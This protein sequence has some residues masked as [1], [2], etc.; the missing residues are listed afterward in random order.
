MKLQSLRARS[1]DC[2]LTDDALRSQVDTSIIQN[3]HIHLELLGANCDKYPAKQH[4]RRVAARLG[5]SHGLIYLEGKPTTYLDDSDQTVPFRQRRYF[6]YLSGVDEPDC[7]LTYDIAQDRLILYVPDFDLRRAIWMGPTLTVD[8]AQERYDVDQARYYSSLSDDINRW[9]AENNEHYPIYLLHASEQPTGT[10]ANL[11]FDAEQLQPAMDT[12]R[13]VKDK[14][15]IDQIRRANKVS[16]L[17]HIQVLRNI[18]KMVNETQI[19]G[20]FLDTCVSLGAKNQAYGIIAAS[21]EN[22]AT[23]HYMKNNEPLA[24]RQFVC[25]DAGAEWNCYASDVTRTFPLQGRWPSDEARDTYR[26][27]EKM[28][29]E[30]IKRIRKGVRFLDLH[31]LAHVIA[32]EGLLDLGILKGGSTEEI[33]KCGVSRVFF[34][35]GLG[36]HVGLEV[37]DVSEKSI[38]AASGEQEDDSVLVPPTSRSPCTFSAPTLEPGM[39]VTVEPGVYFSR[40]ALQNAK[41]QPYAKYIDFNVAARY[42]PVGGV[43]IEDDILVTDGGYENLTTAP[44]GEKMLEIIR[45]GQ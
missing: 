17:A 3:Y 45:R 4:V 22:A 31:I 37:H 39:I 36:H 20:I 25:L 41:Q 18:S 7:Y 33:R 11:Q 10:A 12:C 34:P 5:V 16:G 42:I 43:R 8:E 35:H 6:Y 29:E 32:I 30:C 13:G 23:L 28:Q 38:M 14:H 19:E 15:E 27:V 2:S 1:R 26:I 44:K 40:L 24:D 9:A 21:G